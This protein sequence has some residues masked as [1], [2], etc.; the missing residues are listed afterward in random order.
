MINRQIIREKI[1]DSSFRL[2]KRWK[3]KLLKATQNPHYPKGTIL[4]VVDPWYD[5]LLGRRLVL[6]TGDNGEIALTLDMF[7]IGE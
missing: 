1:E 7:Q 3:I 2:K 4:R 5:T 6:A